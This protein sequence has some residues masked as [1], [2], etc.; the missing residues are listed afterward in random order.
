MA[1]AVIFLSSPGTRMIVRK[2]FGMRKGGNCAELVSL[3]KII[4]RV[5]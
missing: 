2:I 5:I 1:V 4:A 3:G